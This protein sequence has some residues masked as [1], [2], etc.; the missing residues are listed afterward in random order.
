MLSLK[1]LEVYYVQPESG[2]KKIDGAA[3]GRNYSNRPSAPKT[4]KDESNSER[5]LKSAE[6]KSIK[7]HAY[8][9]M[10]PEIGLKTT[11]GEA[12]GCTYTGTVAPET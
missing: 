8:H 7:K 9:Y 11:Y 12:T 6:M 4:D 5:D 1:N 3:V 10:H 2:V